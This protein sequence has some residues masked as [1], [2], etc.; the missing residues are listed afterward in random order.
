M[1]SRKC[2]QSV[3]NLTGPHPIK[4]LEYSILKS[5]FPKD[6]WKIEKAG[7]FGTKALQQ[8][9]WNVTVNA[10]YYEVK[11]NKLLSR[12]TDIK[13]VVADL[14]LEKIYGPE[15]HKLQSDILKIKNSDIEKVTFVEIKSRNGEFCKYDEIDLAWVEKAANPNHSNG[16]ATP[17]KVQVESRVHVNKQIGNEPKEVK[18]E[19]SRGMFKKER[20]TVR[21][22]RRGDQNSKK[23]RLNGEKLSFEDIQSFGKSCKA[24]TIKTLLGKH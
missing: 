11:V 2:K 8:T 1:P 24:K 5:D 20:K 7:T 23:P 21:P 16:A 18:F 4:L 19:K 17:R 13:T 14:V 9:A 6:T 10:G 22:S 12:K 15:V 3:I